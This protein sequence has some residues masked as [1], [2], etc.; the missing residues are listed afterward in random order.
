MPSLR[1][2]LKQQLLQ[3]RLWLTYFRIFWKLKMVLNWNNSVLWVNQAVRVSI[4]VENK[5]KERILPQQNKILLARRT[6]NENIR[7]FISTYSKIVLVLILRDKQTVLP[8]KLWLYVEP[9][10][11]K[12]KTV[13]LGDRFFLTKPAPTSQKDK[14]KIFMSRNTKIVLDV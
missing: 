12:I 14:L 6:A 9:T 4:S 7:I 8:T 1:R 13:L 5:C 2:Q 11:W 10:A 3:R